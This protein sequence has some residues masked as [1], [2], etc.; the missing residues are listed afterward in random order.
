MSFD[1]LI[2]LK[3]CKHQVPA[4]PPNFR[5]TLSKSERLYFILLIDKPRNGTRCLLNLFSAIWVFGRKISRSCIFTG[6]PPTSLNPCPIGAEMVENLSTFHP[7][8]CLPML[9]K[10]IRFCPSSLSAL[11]VISSNNIIRIC[12]LSQ[13]ARWPSFSHVLGAQHSVSAPIKEELAT[14]LVCMID[15]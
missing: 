15:I 14:S 10:Y 7:E 6:T 2:H 1:L 13:R 5:V 11:L 12:R 8:T 9:D 4:L 3:P